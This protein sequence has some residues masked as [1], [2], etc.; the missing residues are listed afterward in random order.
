MFIV[1]FQIS[2]ASVDFCLL[3]HYIIAV[4]MWKKYDLNSKTG[5]LY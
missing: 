3:L 5:E 2:I 4:Y 1:G